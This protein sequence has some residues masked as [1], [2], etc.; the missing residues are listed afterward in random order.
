MKSEMFSDMAMRELLREPVDAAA[1][2]ASSRLKSRLFSQ[3][4]Q[5]EQERGPLRVLSESKAAGSKLCVFEQAVALLPSDA[6]QSRNPCAVCHA[7]VLGERVE[8]APIFW[9]GCPYAQF[10]GH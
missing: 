8:R 6:L 4:I 10:C 9:P 3:L 7:R 5:R 1:P 2:G